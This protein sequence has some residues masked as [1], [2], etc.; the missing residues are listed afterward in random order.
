VVLQHRQLGALLVSTAG[1]QLVEHTTRDTYWGDGGR[2][3]GGQNRLGH[4][5]MEVS[6]LMD[7]RREYGL[8]MM[9]S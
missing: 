2:P 5:L 9:R 8:M 4:L 7:A 3:G 6:D 1:R